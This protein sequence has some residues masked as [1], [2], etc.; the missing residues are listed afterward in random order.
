M[1][2]K[3]FPRG[4]S[5]LLLAG[6]L[7]GCVEKVKGP[8][9]QFGSEKYDFGTVDAGEIVNHVF[10]FTNNGTEMLLIAGVASAGGLTYV[11][12]VTN[13]LE[14]GKR[15]TISVS[16]NTKGLAGKVTQDFLVV[17][18]IRDRSNIPLTLEGTVR[19][20]SAV[21][22]MDKGAAFWLIQTGETV[23]GGSASASKQVKIAFDKAFS[24]TPKIVAT[25]RNEPGFSGGDTFVVTVRSVSTTHFIAN[26]VRVDKAQPW[27]QSPLLD[28]AAWE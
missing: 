25:V 2:R 3:P 27:T 14:P 18:N 12:D 22:G 28:W 9:M 15:G 6:L 11:R 7:S 10:N 26:I 19:E 20:G 8:G 4:L 16:L 13:E 17:T 23:V 24:G 21:A 5:A 1:T